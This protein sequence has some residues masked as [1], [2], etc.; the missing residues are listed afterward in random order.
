MSTSHRHAHTL[1]GPILLPQPL[2][3]EVK[4]CFTVV[5][6]SFWCEIVYDH[7]LFI[8]RR[9]CI[10]HPYLILV[11]LVERFGLNLQPV[12]PSQTLQICMDTAPLN[13]L[14][15]HANTCSHWSCGRGIRAP[16]LVLTDNVVRHKC[17]CGLT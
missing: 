17:H 16:N 4:T 9:F 2:T 12:C 7:V 3:Q 13:I 10:L 5:T 1:T 8:G 11:I 14:E 15:A 6:I